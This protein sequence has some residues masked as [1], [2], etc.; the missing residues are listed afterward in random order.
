LNNLRNELD[1]YEKEIKLS[2][3]RLE[4][5]KVVT[6]NVTHLNDLNQQLECQYLRFTD[7]M[8]TT[9]HNQSL[10]SHLP[11]NDNDEQQQFRSTS[12]TITT[13][14][15]G[16]DENSELDSVSFNDERREEIEDL[17]QTDEGQME[18]Y[19]QLLAE[20]IESLTDRSK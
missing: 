3:E 7:D 16:H 11:K 19:D 4:Q 8:Q 5:L 18:N 9:A 14:T 13:N 10:S 12:S 6:Q 15:N 2:E 20:I 1:D 17:Q